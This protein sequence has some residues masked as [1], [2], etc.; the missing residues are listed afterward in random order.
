[1]DRHITDWS[2]FA[3]DFTIN[4]GDEHVEESV[5]AECLRYLE[6]VDS[7]VCTARLALKINVTDDSVTICNV[8]R[9]KDNVQITSESPHNITVKIIHNGYTPNQTSFEHWSY[10]LPQFDS[11]HSAYTL[12]SVATREVKRNSGLSVKGLLSNKLHGVDNTGNI[13]VWPAEPLLL[14]TLL[15]VERFR[16]LVRGRRVLEIGG[17]MTALAGLGLAV[18]GL[19]SSV[20]VTD[21][22]PDCVKNQVSCIL[23]SQERLPLSIHYIVLLFY[24]FQNVCIEMCK[25]LLRCQQKD[26]SVVD[27]VNEKGVAI[28]PTD[29][30]TDTEGGEGARAVIS[31]KE[32][33]QG[34]QGHQEQG[35]QGQGGQCILPISTQLLHWAVATNAS[36]IATAIHQ[37]QHGAGLFDTVIAADCLFFKDFHRDLLDTLLLLLAPGGVGVFLQPARDGTLQRFVALC[38]ET[39]FFTT[40][41][42]EDYNPQVPIHFG[43][44]YYIR[45]SLLS[46]LCKLK[47]LLKVYLYHL[48]GVFSFSYSLLPESVL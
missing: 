2:G 11:E 33:Q 24:I 43:C 39:G 7:T 26:S 40:E 16:A 23:F 4:A 36:Q 25:Q 3:L 45:C 14:H 13:C 8:F 28:I 22:H 35:Q 34:Q 27:E 31:S 30:G 9:M 20:V 32:R 19:C 17:G 44:T 29:A 37:Q 41:I 1:M 18:S 42:V 6:S 10:T 46:L 48:C 21:G 12:P 38:A 5:I 47:C 15:T